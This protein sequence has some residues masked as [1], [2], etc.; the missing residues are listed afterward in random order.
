MRK[1]I[2]SITIL[3]LLLTSF[4]FVLAQPGK[5]EITFFYSETCSY[6]LKEEKF[7]NQLEEKYNDLVIHRYNIADRESV[8]LLKDLYQQYQVPEE[9]WGMIPATFLKE[10]YLIGYGGDETT[11]K[12][13]ENCIKE[14]LVETE[15]SETGLMEASLK[16]IKLPILGEIEISNFS[17]LLLSV[18]L[19]TLDGFN[20]C[21]MIALGF[22]LS[23]LI[24]SSGTR[25]RIILIGGTFILVSGLVY[26]LFIAT[27]LNLFL[28]TFNIKFITN[29]V[30]I[31]IILSAI[32][33]LRD[34]FTDVICKLC[35][36]DPAKQNIFTKIQQK[37]F[38]KM[39][40]FSSTDVPLP[41]ALLGIAVVAAG[42]N[43]I[44]LACS[45]GLPLVFTKILT[46]W[47]LSK[48]SYYFYLLV[49]ILFYMIDDFVIFL[50][51]VYTLKIT[52]T[53]Q[54][55]LKLVTLISGIV[56]LIL[57]LIM[58]INPEILIL[59]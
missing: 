6:C 49:Y 14:C 27:W 37:L 43:M 3:I 51:A 54:K 1:I 46:S 5:A 44:E 38:A 35:E 32:F 42:V 34:Y 47:K 17:P 56:L 39:Q 30:A 19:G 53:S 33:I 15:E 25:R 55:Y 18:V 9:Q 50:I 22:L 13:I 26:F 36:T 8:E 29:L 7:L 16:K 40:Q 10:K 58:L 11:G 57:G 59:S 45:F 12:E 28:I 2:F 48:A 23:V 41:I 52:Q 20:A 24:A 21:A 31:I 4:D